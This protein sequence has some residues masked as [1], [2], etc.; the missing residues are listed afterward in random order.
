MGGREVFRSI[1]LTVGGGG[2]IG[3]IR[4]AKAVGRGSMI[5][6]PPQ[7]VVKLNMTSQIAYSCVCEIPILK[8]AA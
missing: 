4:N 2:G 8:A 5:S 3:N 6:I 1:V 7:M